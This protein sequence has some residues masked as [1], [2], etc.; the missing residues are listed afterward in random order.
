MLNFFEI[1]NSWVLVDL[2]GYGYAKTSKATKATFSKMIRSY[3]TQRVI[4]YILAF[5]LIDI[6]HSLQKIDEQ[7][8]GWCGQNG[9]PICMVFTKSDKL[10]KNHDCSTCP[11]Y[12]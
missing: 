9:V 10:G 8:I 3:L 11:N 7:F 6:R 12:Q 2:P 1:N 4:I 5:V